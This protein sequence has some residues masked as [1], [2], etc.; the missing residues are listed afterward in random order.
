[1]KTS[2]QIKKLGE[3]IK[4]EYGKPL[5]DSK[6]HPD[7]KYPV[8][9]ANGEKNRTN[10]FF[11][12]KPSIIVGRKGSAGELNLTEEKFWPLDVTYFVTFD[13]TKYDLGFIYNLLNTLELTKLAKGVK[14][15]INR[16]D[17]YSIKVDTPPISE[18]KRIVKKLD[19]VFEKVTKAKEAAEKNLQNS[20][21][22]FESYLNGIFV[23]PSKDWDERFLGEVLQKT[24]T[25]DPTKKPKEKF[26][27]IDVSSV[28]KETKEIVNTSLLIGKDAPSRARKLVKTNDVIFATVRPTHARVAI[29]TEKYNNQVCS[30][31]YFILRTND[32]MNNKLVFYFLLTSS[33]NRQMEKLQ[34]GASYPAVTDS[35]VKNIKILFPKP[36]TEQKKI[37]DKLDVLSIETNKL[38]KIYKKKLACLE[39]LKKSIL[40]QAFEGKL[41]VQEQTSSLPVPSPY[42][43]NQVHAAIVGQVSKDGGE[44]T[45]VAVAKYDHLLQEIFGISLGYQFQTHLFGPF[46][47][48]IKKLV[49]SGLSPRNRWF[50]KRNGMIVAGSNITALLSRSSNLYRNAQTAMIELA[51]LG[52]TKMNT[53]KVELLST[54]CHAIKECRSTDLK[55][56]RNFMDQWQTNNNQTK[57]QKFSLEQTKKCLDFILSKRLEQKLLIFT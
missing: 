20:K 35:E 7:G 9:G 50:V 26:V 28:D 30:T 5:P 39:E 38:E 14:P 19:E 12:N 27:Y 13:S 40:K 33:F 36:L 42:I 17:V 24:E 2:W 11:Y 18:Q 44:T 1:M 54:V 56:I 16:N 8:Y 37:I 10:E 47:V 21:K 15:G 49:S 48:E 31:G 22:L 25:V 23:N 52:I 46:D 29:I 43:R 41:V 55:I 51:R 57:A 3:I 53:D 45:E 4:L 32:L 6:R 34:K